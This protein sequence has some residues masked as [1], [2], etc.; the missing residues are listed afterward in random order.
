MRLHRNLVFTV[1]DNI[2]EIFN[3]NA[4]ADKVIAKAL[5]RDKRWGAR[6]RAFIAETTYEIV[7][8]KRLYSQIAEINE[9]YSRENLY[10]LF[11]VWATLRGI[12]LPE[13]KQFEGTPTRKIKGRFDELSKIRKF[14]QSIPDWM[15][16]MRV[17]QLG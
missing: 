15:D 10:K 16:E 6:D 17:S 8:W 7:R 14:K 4:Y 13:W 11:C 5:K 3:K 1:V 9:H 2:N 12:K